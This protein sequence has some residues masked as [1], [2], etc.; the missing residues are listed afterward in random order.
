MTEIEITTARVLELI[1]TYGAEPGAW[2]ETE[3]NA[4]QAL[5]EAQPDEFSAALFDAQA[6]DTMLASEHLPDPSPDLPAR[7]LASAPRAQAKPF[8]HLLGAIF[9]RGVRWPAGATLASL[10]MGIVGGYAYA[11]TGYTEI[12]TADQAYYTAFGYTQVGDWLAAED[13]E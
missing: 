9:P 10:A 13:S 4:A 2:P 12:D 3:R 1:E 5:I 7:I 6:L 11:S 8:T